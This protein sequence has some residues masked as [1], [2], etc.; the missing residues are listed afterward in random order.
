M[1][2]VWHGIVNPPRTKNI[3]EWDYSK[4][5]IVLKKAKKWGASCWDQR[6]YYFSLITRWH[7]IL[8]GLQ[9]S[10]YAW[11][12]PWEVVH[13]ADALHS[14]DKACNSILQAFFIARTQAITFRDIC[15]LKNSCQ[16]HL[17]A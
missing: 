16:S 13:K 10:P 8:R 14:P 12:K 5:N 4:D 9:Q 17:F 2:T 6:W 15:I 11:E 3:V 1:A 7:L